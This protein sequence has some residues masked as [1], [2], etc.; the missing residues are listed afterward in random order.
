MHVGILEDVFGER[1]RDRPAERIVPKLL[2]RSLY[3]GKSGF[4][5]FPSSGLVL[6]AEERAPGRAQSADGGSSKDGSAGRS[7][8]CLPGPRSTS[9]GYDDSCVLCGL[10]MLSYHSAIRGYA[11]CV[12]RTTC[13]V[14]TTRPRMAFLRCRL[15]IVSW[16]KFITRSH[17]VDF[18][19][20]MALLCV[21]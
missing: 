13:L 4:L 6:S 16:H 2:F 10:G 7:Q 9:K 3:D 17:D 11:V 18:V 1:P 5:L 8:G 14:C 19:L 21:A 20:C 15:D 12:L